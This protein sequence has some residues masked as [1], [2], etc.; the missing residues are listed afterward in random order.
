M[1]LKKTFS[2]QWRLFLPLTLLL[3]LI[4]GFLVVYMVRHEK[5]VKRDNLELQL[6][7][8]NSTLLQA[9]EEGKDLQQVVDFIDRYNDNTILDALR[10]SVMTY[11]NQ[12]LAATDV[13]VLAESETHQIAPE[14]EMIRKNDDVDEVTNIRPAFFDHEKMIINAITSNDG[15]IQAICATPYNKGVTRA[16]AY[17]NMV[18]LLVAVLTVVVTG[19]AFYL[20]SLVSRNVYI[21]RD[22]ATKATEGRIPDIEHMTFGHDE[23][24]EVS[25]RIVRLYLKMDKALIRS[26]HEHEV[27][28]RAVNER[29]RVKRQMSNNIN[30]ELKT[31]VGIIKGYL[32]TIISDPDMPESLRRSFLEKAQSHADRLTMLLKDVSSITRLEDGSQQVEISDFDF[33]DLVYS[34]ANDIEVSHTSGNMEF[35]YRIPFDCMVRGNYAL[36]TNAL[37]NLVRN[38]ANYSHG[39]KIELNI[40][41]E[42]DTTYEF[43]FKDNGVGVSNEHL[44][45][46]FE[47][48]YRVDEGRARK[49]GGTGL[50]LA[51]VK[52][53]F[54]AIGGNISVGPAS[55]HGLRFVFTI[56]KAGC[57][58][59]P[60]KTDDATEVSHETNNNQ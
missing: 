26:K 37:I 4:I 12:I 24:G 1:D 49:S 23:L 21:L 6:K 8:I 22:F 59:A 19:V 10:I 38:S 43:E 55:P 35:E 32:D 5:D 58:V 54:S 14:L 20:C 40:L 25:R 52:S 31:P 45:R 36:L 18:W 27:A 15:A 13:P 17:D 9:Y 33:H 16:L 7:N 39:T 48:F 60:V 51:I 46:L 53:T 50:G 3:W 41:G 57:P 28:M 30:H 56:P 11:D 2:L 42:T 34:M 29:E 47:R 44:S